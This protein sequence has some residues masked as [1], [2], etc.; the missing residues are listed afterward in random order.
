MSML[1]EKRLPLGEFLHTVPQRSECC[2]SSWRRGLI[3]LKITLRMFQHQGEGGHQED[4]FCVQDSQL[5]QKFLPQSWQRNQT[6][7][8][9]KERHVG[10]REWG[11]AIGHQRHPPDTSALNRSLILTPPQQGAL[12]EPLA[13]Q[14]MWCTEK[15]WNSHQLDKEWAIEPN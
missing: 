6:D 13:L 14:R 3:L 8:T 2:R 15:S 10:G 5:S 12:Q 4:E 11:W 9:M 1:T 7:R